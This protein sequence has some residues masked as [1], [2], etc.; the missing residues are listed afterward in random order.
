MILKIRR[1][2]FKGKE[3][4]LG[5]CTNFS[6]IFLWK[7]LYKKVSTKKFVQDLAGGKPPFGGSWKAH[8]LGTCSPVDGIYPQTKVWDPLPENVAKKCFEWAFWRNISRW[9]TKNALVSL[10]KGPLKIRLM[11]LKIRLMTLKIRRRIFKGV[12]TACLL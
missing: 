6:E 10:P 9:V 5:P 11:T 2:I 7:S 12:L 4:L 1:R 3:D 8:G